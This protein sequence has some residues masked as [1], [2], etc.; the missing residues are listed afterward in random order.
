MRVV[1]AD[2]LF[3]IRD[4]LTR[5]L[6]AFGSTVVAA[7][8]NPRDL[9]T[10]VSELEPDIAVIDVRMPPTF[11]DEGCGRRWRLADCTRG[12]RC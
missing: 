5:M 3:L 6:E 11:T 10:A 1:L 7:V 8:D 4:G 9:L 12:Y 2:D